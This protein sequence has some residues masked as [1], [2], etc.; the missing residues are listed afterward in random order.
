MENITEDDVLTI[1]QEC[2]VNGRAGSDSLW[3]WFIKNKDFIEVTREDIIMESW[4]L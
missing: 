4:P 2:L 3:A 1:L